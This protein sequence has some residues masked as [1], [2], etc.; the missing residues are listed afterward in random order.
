MRIWLEWAPSSWK[1]SLIKKLSELWHNVHYEAAT[2]LFYIMGINGIEIKDVVA[3][4]LDFQ[5][6]VTTIKQAQLLGAWSNSL[7]FFDTTIVWD[8][9]YRRMLWE[10]MEESEALIQQI[11]YDKIF[12]TLWT[13][14]IEDNGIRYESDD[15]NKQLDRA[16]RQA[17][18]DSWYELIELPTFIEPWSQLTDELV[19]E[20][21]AQRVDFIFWHID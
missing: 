5:R 8:L 19:R 14:E 15:E 18:L 13:W 11:R 7:H 9:A 20:A 16:K 21:V 2:Q 10:W 17:V 4:W 3:T 6:Q 1:S 12:Y